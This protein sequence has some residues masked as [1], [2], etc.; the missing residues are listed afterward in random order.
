MIKRRIYLTFLFLLIL[1]TITIN[2]KWKVFIDAWYA[3]EDMEEDFGNTHLYDV[4]GVEKDATTEE[5]KKS[6]RKLSKKYHPDKVKDQNSNNRFSEIAEA[7]EILSDEE[8]RKVYDLHGLEAAKNVERHKVEDDPMDSFNFYDSFFGDGFRREEKKKADN[9]T[10]HVEMNLEQLYNGEFFSVIY[11]RDVNCLKGDDCIIRKPECSGKGHKTTTEQVAPGF[12]MQ[13]KVKDENCID[14]GKAWNPKCSYCPNGMKEEKTTE[15]TLEVEPGMANY[16]KIV[17]EKKGKQEIG[18][19][20]GDVVFIIQTKK[21]KTYVRKN[22]DLHQTYE[23]SLKD[24][25]IGFSKDIDHI[26]GKPIHINKQTVTFHNDILKVQNKGMPIRNTNK[27]GDLYITF[28]VQFPKKLT[29][30]QKKGISDLF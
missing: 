13:K 16:D 5:I 1:K 14:R 24:A 20:N 3:H 4:L 10:I 27:F 30:E 23:I 7:Y 28:S 12:I 19:E 21:H 26:S 18:H 11:T 25:L 9:L 6:F 29:E 2:K 8:K 15:L 22:N 17:F